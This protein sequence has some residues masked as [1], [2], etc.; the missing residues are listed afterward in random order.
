M[1]PTSLPD[2]S[3]PEAGIVPRRFLSFPPCHS[4]RPVILSEAKNLTPA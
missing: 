2:R 1:L 3:T 4:S